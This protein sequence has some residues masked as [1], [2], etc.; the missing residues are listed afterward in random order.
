MLPSLCIAIGP[1]SAVLDAEILMV[2]KKRVTLRVGLCAAV[3]PTTYRRNYVR[4]TW[5]E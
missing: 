4:I 2:E 3:S 5:G 1:S